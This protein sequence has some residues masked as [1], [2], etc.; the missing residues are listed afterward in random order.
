MS[1]VDRDDVEVAV[2]AHVALLAAGSDVGFWGSGWLHHPV[3][4]WQKARELER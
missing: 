4:S 1:E 3:E 2:D